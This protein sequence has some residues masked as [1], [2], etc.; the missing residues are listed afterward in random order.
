M[1]PTLDIPED[2]LPAK[3]MP[4]DVFRA[5]GDVSAV[6]EGDTRHMVGHFATFGDWYEVRSL[7]EGHF[8]ERIAPG[9]FSKT[10]K[11]GSPVVLFDHGMDPTIGR[12]ALGTPQV[13]EDQRGAAY[14][15]ALFD[16]SFN[17][18][19]EPGLRA[20][21][22]S[23]SFRFKS[24]SDKDEWDFHPERSVH[25]PTGIPEVTRREVR[26]VEFGPTTLPI[27][28]NATAS[29][30]SLTDRY[31]DHLRSVDTSAY[32]DAMRSVVDVRTPAGETTGAATAPSPEPSE[33]TRPLIATRKERA[34]AIARTR[35]LTK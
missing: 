26:V 6:T 32:E 20:G 9:A 15:V 24:I 21:A 29:V 27:N 12:K 10:L 31:Y 3:A 25:N 8:M 35:R 11:E 1:P 30:R 5:V 4:V 14:D 22:Y 23:S 19:L 28:P 17:R 34:E 18:D 33:D 7:I 16:T 2:A 13:S